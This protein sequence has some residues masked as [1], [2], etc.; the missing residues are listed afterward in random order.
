[1]S[2]SRQRFFPLVALGCLAFVGLAHR[3]SN[4]ADSVSSPPAVNYSEQIKPILADRCYACHGPDAAQRKADLELHVREKAIREAIVPGKADAS[5]LIERITTLDPD[6]RMPPADSKKPPLTADEIELVKRWINEGAPFDAHWSYIKP[7]RPPLPEGKNASWIR[8]P[9][10]RFVALRQEE[11]GLAPAPEADRR[12]L[13]RRLSLDLIGLPP[14]PAEID[15]FMVD[16][17][18]DAYG[19]LVDR[20]LTSP[21]YGERMAQYWL[22]V[23]RY[24]DSAGYH[25]DNDR[26]VWLYRDYVIQAFNDNKRFDE[27]TIE[28]IAGDLLAAGKWDGYV[29]PER[30]G[31]RCTQ[32]V[33]VAF[34]STRE[35]RI[36]SGYNRLLQTTEEG[37]AQPKEYTAKYSADRVRNTAAVWLGATMG[38]CECHDHKFDPYSTRDFYRLAAFFADVNERA[39]GRQEQTPMPTPEQEARIKELDGQIAA[40][41]VELDQPRPEV[42]AAQAQWEQ[43]VRN[44]KIEWTTLTPAASTSAGGATFAPQPDGSLMVGGTNPDKDVF[45]FAVPLTQKGVTAIRLEVLPDD[46]LPAHGPGRAANGNFVLHE[47]EATLN[48][49]PLKWSVASASHSQKDWAA[50]G[51]ADGKPNTGWAILPEVGKPSHLVLETAADAG[52]GNPATLTVKLHQNYGTSHTIGR[53]RLS[54][55]TSPRPVRAEGVDAL[56]KNIA[57]ALA[58]EPANRN[59]EQKRTLAAYYRTIAPLL[60]P[61]RDKLAAFEKQKGDI[62]K[63]APTTLVSMSVEPRVVRVLPRGNWL[64][65]SGEIMSPGV[66]EFLAPLNVADRRPSRVDLA[67]WMASR[68]NPLVARVFVNRLWKLFFGQGIVK[69]L[70]DLGTQGAWPTHPLL[71]DWLAVEFV[72]SGWDVKHLVRLMVTSNSYR[73]SSTTSPE[74]RQK[75]PANQWLARQNRFRLEAEMVRDNALAIS[76]LL[77][78]KIGGPSVK[79]YQPAGYWAHLNFPVREWANDHGESQYRRGLYTWWQRTFLHPSLLAFNASTREECTAER[80]R[81]NTPLQALVLLNDPTYVEAARALA[82]RALRE[83]S[84]GPAERI[85]FAWREA[86]GRDPIAEETDVLARLYEKNRGAYAA[87]P[88]AAAELAQ[89]G[90]LKPPDGFDVVELAAWTAVCRA[91]LNLHE[92]ITRY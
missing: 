89:N 76:G 55:S 51:A 11:H 71:L 19:Q 10:D 36:A 50:E 6:E 28:Q 29:L 63:S 8:N 38:C 85:R 16:Q 65:D 44:R 69:T 78:D 70:D 75:D 73:Q 92:T 74:M 22:D 32:N 41:R 27:F 2:R 64:D 88:A 57:D 52:D 54:A 26:L 53:L 30:P 59:D 81:S 18:S 72:E 60:Q 14:K 61:L 58:V 1:M 4:A 12:T 20:L 13:I 84:A 39:V 90:D 45:T 49:A 82:A 3:P 40:V 31:G 5:P 17:R 91:I 7:Q 83:A 56:P 87:D 9:I 68:D 47:V 79:P 35:Q 25:S 80:P 43:D 86:L 33:P 62:I 23:V 77:S 37:G 24:A 15:A 48:D 21:H 42:D 66:P 46:S 34:S 67:M